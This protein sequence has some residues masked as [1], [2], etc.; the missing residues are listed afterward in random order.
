[1]VSSDSRSDSTES[2]IPPSAARVLAKAA[3]VA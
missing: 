2:L 3:A 1:V